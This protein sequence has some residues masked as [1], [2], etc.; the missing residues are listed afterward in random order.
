MFGF[1]L[2][3]ILD[4]ISI[5]ACVAGI[6]LTLLTVGCTVGYFSDASYRDE[7]DKKKTL[8]F[9]K[10]R[11]VWTI[12]VIIWL[13]AVFVPTTKQAAFIWLAP[14]IV[15]NGAVKDTV[16]NIPELAKLGTEYLKELLKEAK[17]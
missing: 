14:Q 10:V 2:L 8:E 17:E 1:Y 11:L 7:E 5:M 9:Y 4:N 6:L 3:T 16:K 13:V 12:T 15:E